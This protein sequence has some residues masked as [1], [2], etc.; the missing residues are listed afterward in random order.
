M[1][2]AAPTRP[3]A[4][5]RPPRLGTPLARLGWVIAVPAVLLAGGLAWANFREPS[6][7]D[8]VVMQVQPEKHVVCVP[9][10][11][12][13]DVGLCGVI[14]TRHPEKIIAGAHVTV[15]VHQVRG[16]DPLLIEVEPIS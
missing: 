6:S 12:G 3:A 11:P 7:Y 2:T 1:S 4:R 13:A 9:E 10:H 15:T 14:V 8:T 5:A 16:I